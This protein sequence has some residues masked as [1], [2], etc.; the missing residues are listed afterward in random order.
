MSSH[1]G[2]RIEIEQYRGKVTVLLVKQ[3]QNICSIVGL[4][5]SGIK[6]ELQKRIMLGKDITFCALAVFGHGHAHT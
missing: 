4:R 1:S 5:T 3:L 2:S 6:A